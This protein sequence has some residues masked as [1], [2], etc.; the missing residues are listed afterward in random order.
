MSCSADYIE[1]GASS[2][3]SDWFVEYLS[4]G[5]DKELLSRRLSRAEFVNLA[6]RGASI[7][8]DNGLVRGDRYV[9]Y[10]TENRLEDLVLRLS[11]VLSGTVPVTVNWQ[12]DDAERIA[13]K[14]DVTQSKLA[15]V[16]AGSDRAALGSRIKIID[17]AQALASSSP[18]QRSVVDW[19]VTKP[20]DD[21]IIIFTS[22]TTGK[23]K[24]VRLSY[25]A[26][27]ANRATFEDFLQVGDDSLLECV[28]T[29]PFHHTNSTAITDWCLRRWK[30]NSKI[31]L[32]QRYTTAYWKVVAAAG[33]DLTFGE[34]L[35]VQ[36]ATDDERSRRRR[37]TVVCPLVSRHVDF[38]DDLCSKSKLPVPLDVFREA[39][40][41]V[42]LLLGS[43]PVGPTTV[44]RLE[45]WCGRLPVVRFGSTETCLQVAG[46]P[47]SM[48][49]DERLE[50]FKRGWAHRFKDE[51]K[52]GYYIGTDHRPWTSVRVV[53]SV[54]SASE[55]YLVDCEEGEPGFFITRGAN[56]MTAYVGNNNSSPFSDD[57]WYLKLGDVGFALDKN[58]YW[59]S[60][61]SAMLIRGG[62]NYAYEQI[63]A[64]LKQFVKNQ[65]DI[66]DVEL[67]VVGIKLN[68]EHEDSCCL[69]IELPPGH[70][71]RDVIQQT[72]L[73]EAKTKVSKGAKV[74]KLRFAPLPKNF[75][76]IVL[77][78]DLV[79]QWK[80]ELGIR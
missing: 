7:L 1:E 55:K 72:F 20:E 79:A 5:E 44:E 32:L 2:S 76:G 6:E 11:S 78:R 3:S 70:P 35:V 27:S 73:V 50:A 39:A 80:A 56:L 77:V 34:D 14:A 33:L 42:A 36:K 71:K 64:E 25:G 49:E 16:D 58:L 74:D 57:G 41:R 12:A 28:V 19:E 10:F 51:A 21:R 30:Q 13:Y 61:D 75:K 24:G 38:L 47:L 59:Q 18:T 8:V 52:P 9:H 31:R 69:T 17:A 40:S 62:A 45:K 23:P 66:D 60:R 54:D 37:R 53:K 65:Y 63:N 43:A 15:M 46:T 68:S 67:A 48:S 4:V 22:G 29:N 26:Y